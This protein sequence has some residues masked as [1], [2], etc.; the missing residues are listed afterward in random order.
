MHKR[1]CNVS[2]YGICRNYNDSGAEDQDESDDDDVETVRK[3]MSNLKTMP[4][5]LSYSHLS[6][7]T[8]E[9]CSI[10]C[11]NCDANIASGRSV[12]S[13]SCNRCASCSCHHYK[14]EIHY[15]NRTNPGGY[16]HSFL[17]VSGLDYKSWMIHDSKSVAE[18]TWFNNYQW[19]I[20]YCQCENHLG[21][22]FKSTNYET[23]LPT[24]FGLRKN[25]IRLEI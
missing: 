11:K 14:G 16:T 5:S 1:K 24:F 2:H 3:A 7:F 25:A 22:Q 8:L 23:D 4:K 6:L 21:W 18:H 10:H 19:G 20:L 9:E 17:T 13:I 15:H 12:I